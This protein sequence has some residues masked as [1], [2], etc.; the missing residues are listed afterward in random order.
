MIR[1]AKFSLAVAI[2]AL[3]AAVLAQSAAAYAPAGATPLRT[4]GS[5]ALGPVAQTRS[6]VLAL[7]PSNLAGLEAF[8]AQPQHP[9]LKAGQFLQRFGPTAA[10]VSSVE[11]WASAQ[12]LTVDSV[13]PDDLLVRVTGTTSALGAALGVG[14]ERFAAAGSSY[15]SSTGTAS[16]PASLAGD[17]TAI[18]GLSDLERARVEVVHRSSS[19][20]TPGLSYP[21]SYGP[22]EFWSL[23]EAPSAQTGSGQQVSVIAAGDVSQPKADLTQFES[24]FGLPTVTW[25]QIDVGTPSDETEGDD[26]W[27]LDTQYSTAF[28]PGVSQVNVYDGSSLEDPSILETID[29]WVTDDATSQASFSAG[30]CELLADEAGFVASLDTV[31]AEAAAQGQTLF[32]ASGDTGSQCPA[33][34]AENGVPAG[35][36]GVN[37]PASSPYA[38]GAGGTTVLDPGTEIGWYAGGGGSSLIES[39][40]AWQENAGGSFLGVKRGVPDV[41]LDADPNSGFDVFIDGQEEVIGGTSADAPSWQGI[42]ARAEGAHADKLGFAGPVIYQTEPASAFHEITIGDNG[43]Y[44]CTPGWNYVTGRGTPDI[45]AFVAGA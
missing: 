18:L 28:A 11:A 31:L 6:I 27:D 9:Q 17:V 15:V 20:S 5:T 24:H 2:A 3:A 45:T 37:Y 14:F 13:S 40:P 41:S 22:Q 42:W 38:I 12:G 16:L 19:S 36:P 34:V 7:T 29:R 33:L 39:T 30:E 26:E 4:E 25:N 21:T 8:D 44:P 43:L 10:Q 23:Y 1:P 32:T 35:L